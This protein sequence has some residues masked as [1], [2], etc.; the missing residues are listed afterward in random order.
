MGGLN[1]F[2]L[3]FMLFVAVYVLYY[4]IRGEGKIYENDYPAVMQD[5]HKKLLRKFCWIIGIGIIPLTIL[6]FIFQS[7]SLYGIFAWANI[8]FVLGCVIVYLVLFRK[9]FGKYVYPQKPNKR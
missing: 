6:E 3:Y 2:M 9:R 5:E 8:A 1:D 4:A 7:N